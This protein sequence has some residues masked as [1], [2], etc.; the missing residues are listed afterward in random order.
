MSPLS[1][2]RF[3]KVLEGFDRTVLSTSAA[4]VAAGSAVTLGPCHA[5]YSAAPFTGCSTMTAALFVSG[6]GLGAGVAKGFG[7]RGQ[8]PKI[9][10][11]SWN[12]RAG[13][14]SPARIRALLL[15]M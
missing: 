8:S 11:A 4:Y 15:G 3:W 10:S 1:T 13:V 2:R 12:P 9:C 6:G 14:I 5:M 7:P